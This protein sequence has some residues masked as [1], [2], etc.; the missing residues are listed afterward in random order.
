M[1]WTILWSPHAIRNAKQIPRPFLV[2]I[3]DDLLALA[4]EPD[5][6]RS[7]KKIRGQSSGTVYSHRVGEYRV[8]LD[9]GQDYFV[10]LVIDLGHRKNIYRDL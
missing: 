10:I 2:R 9:I 6:R 3:R 5:P 4:R 8:I 7:L 1:T